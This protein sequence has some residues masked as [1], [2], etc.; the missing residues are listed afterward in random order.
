MK[1][2][3]TFFEKVWNDHVIT[4]LGEGALLQIDRLFL[5][6][7]TGCSAFEALEKLGRR[8]MCKDQVRSP[9]NSP[10]G[11]PLSAAIWPPASVSSP[12]PAAN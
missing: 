11:W 8:P 2:P 5:H 1:A 6:E 10:P 9:S 12:L 4:T 7:L 3:Q